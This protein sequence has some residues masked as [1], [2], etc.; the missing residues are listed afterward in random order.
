MTRVHRSQPRTSD[1]LR[2]FLLGF[3]GL[4]LELAL[5]RYLPSRIW[6]LGYFPNFVLLAAFLG[7][8]AGFVISGRLS[9]RASDRMGSAAAALLFSII[10]IG[11][12]L[13]P[14]VPGLGGGEGTLGGEL[15]FTAVVRDDSNL[16]RI[17]FL[18]LFLLVAATF[19]CITQRTARFF[20]LFPP[21]TAYSLD[22]AGSV[23][24]ILAFMAISASRTPA[25]VWFAAIALLFLA[26]LVRHDGR[27]HRTALPLLLAIGVLVFLPGSRRAESLPAGM[28]FE[29]H[30]SPYQMV[31]YL[32]SP[33]GSP[34]IFVNRIPHQTILDGPALERSFY[35][36]PHRARKASG[37]APYRN[38]L[39]IGAGAG[40][41]VA[42]ALKGGAGIVEA[43]EIDP[44]I[45]VL[46]REK[47]GLGPYRDPRVRLVIDD[48]RSVLTRAKGPYDL[49]IFALTDSLVKSSS[50]S[51]LRLE[52]FLFTRESFER[53]FSLLS[54]E[55]DILLYNYYRQDW[56][57]HRLMDTLREATGR[58]P[59]ILQQGGGFY[60]IAVG[61]KDNPARSASS[62]RGE[63]PTDDW[64]FPYL[65][66]RG[67][68]AFYLGALGILALLTSV[69]MWLVRRREV[70]DRRGG[71][72]AFRT[73]F[74]A[75]GSAFL[76]LESKSVVQFSLLYGTTWWNSSIVFL[77]ILLL[78]LLANRLAPH[79]PASWGRTV[80]PGLLLAS[81]LATLAVPLSRFLYVE[82]VLSRMAGAAVFSLL[83]V[84][85]ANLYFSVMFQRQKRAVDLF[86]WNLL[87]SAAGGIL[88]YSSM[89]F[90]YN[91]LAVGVA[92]L[93]GAAL[94]SFR[95]AERSGR[96]P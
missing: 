93:Y 22:I 19:T 79:L 71:S 87:G 95:A 73:G 52:N 44:V 12:F 48:G 45:A 13:K 16:S 26:A 3:L 32:D 82:N 23:A 25:W 43:V 49:V 85:F 88:E 63:V 84:F 90:G 77:A 70:R 89:A 38:V 5:I 65:R 31:S 94:L 15:F 58:E 59:R 37:G 18:L 30:W 53:A 46:G 62:P 57:A 27:P 83:P 7:M 24:G 92:L 96:V 61:R 80:I 91:A 60:Q 50:L 4:F 1:A 40:N 17:L 28:T 41:D 72:W 54:P 55:G 76:L 21:L 86:G 75:M 6:Y 47:N 34:T 56:F 8:G 68:P 81:C 35:M 69:G 14:V 67:V 64:P 33:P 51:Q 39:V 78:V 2:L 66:K 29:M 10:A 20:S 74:F 42:A 9:D 11:Y 36:K